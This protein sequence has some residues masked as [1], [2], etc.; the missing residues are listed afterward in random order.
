MT[1][2]ANPEALIMRRIDLAASISANTGASVKELHSST[3][4]HF[5]AGVGRKSPEKR[6][7]FPPFSM[8]V[9]GFARHE[10]MLI[11]RLLR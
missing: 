5:I 11:K 2:M 10:K 9:I 4:D 1:A 7:F 8:S 3:K 6:L